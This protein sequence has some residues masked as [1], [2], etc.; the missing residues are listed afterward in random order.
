MTIK[1]DVNNSGLKISIC[2]AFIYN[3][4]ALDQPLHLSLTLKHRQVIMSSDWESE[5]EFNEA[6][7]KL[8]LIT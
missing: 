7:A 3:P 2:Q 6:A 1:H 8:P 5:P 4:P